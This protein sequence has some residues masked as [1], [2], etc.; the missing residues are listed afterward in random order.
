MRRIDGKYHIENEQIVKTTNG[1]VVPT[2]EPLFLLRGRDRNAL[3]LLEA[4]YAICEADGCNEEHL[5]GIDRIICEFENFRN[6]NR[7]V[8]KQPGCTYGK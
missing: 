3:P 4:Y 6:R 2:E 8:M 5:S 1:T 7:E